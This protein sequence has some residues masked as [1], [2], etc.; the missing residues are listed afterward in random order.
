MLN[1][2]LMDNGPI[3]TYYDQC[4]LKCCV[5]STLHMLSHAACSLWLPVHSSLLFNIRYCLVTMVIT[6]AFIKTKNIASWFTFVLILRPK[7]QS[8]FFFGFPYGWKWKTNPA[9]SRLSL[10]WLLYSERHKWTDDHTQPTQ[11]L[12]A[13][14][15][16]LAPRWWS[17]ETGNWLCLDQSINHSKHISIPPYVTSELEEHKD[18][19][20]LSGWSVWKAVSEHYRMLIH[21]T[22]C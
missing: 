14:F 9:S 6:S 17:A 20:G 8:N 11:V 2:I 13:A 1:R 7:M 4:R 22:K 19:S 10:W 12:L 5:H 15:C 3:C 21:L 18:C 16:C